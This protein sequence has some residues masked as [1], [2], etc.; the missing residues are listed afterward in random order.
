[1]LN[2]NHESGLSGFGFHR[3]GLVAGALAG[4]L[5]AVAPPV[6][7][8]TAPDFGSTTQADLSYG[9]NS[10][11]AS[12]TLPEATGATSYSL[13]PASP[14]G[15]DFAAGTRALSGRVTVPPRRRVLGFMLSPGGTSS[16][17]SAAA[18]RACSE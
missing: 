15:L 1:M 2:P 10:A 11:I 3:M 4:L 6:S 18:A 12:T 7:A 8:Q 17:A 9:R 13:N 14:F 16:V 5:L